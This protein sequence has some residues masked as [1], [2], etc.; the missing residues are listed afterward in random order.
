[1]TTGVTPAP[2]VETGGV[3]VLTTARGDPSALRA[4][5]DGAVVCERSVQAATAKARR[6]NV[7]VRCARWRDM[8]G[9]RVSAAW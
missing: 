8:V 6:A 7:G 1:M 3:D 2:L 9:L 5:G 4:T